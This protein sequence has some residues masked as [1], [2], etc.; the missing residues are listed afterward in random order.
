MGGSVTVYDPILRRL[1]AKTIHIVIG[2]EYRL[3]LDN[4]YSAVEIDAYNVL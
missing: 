3:A 1:A 2:V 4:L